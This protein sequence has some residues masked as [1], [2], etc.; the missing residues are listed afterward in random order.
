MG[1][2]LDLVEVWNSIPL[3]DGLQLS[4]HRRSLLQ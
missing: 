1:W 3:F 4:R 2:E